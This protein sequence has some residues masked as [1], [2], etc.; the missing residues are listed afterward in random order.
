VKRRGDPLHHKAR[1]LV[2]AVAAAAALFIPTDSAE[3]LPCFGS[4][5]ACHRRGLLVVLRPA[6]LHNHPVPPKF[7]NYLA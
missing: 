4:H 2:A 6:L 1:H 3:H 7:T 5:Q